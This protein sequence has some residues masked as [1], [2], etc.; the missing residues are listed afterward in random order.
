MALLKLNKGRRAFFNRAPARSLT[1]ALNLMRKKKWVKT[2]KVPCAVCLKPVEEYLNFG[3]SRTL[4]GW[5]YVCNKC[6]REIE[7]KIV[8]AD[9]RITRLEKI[10]SMTK[11]EKAVIVFLILS[12]GWILG[13]FTEAIAVGNLKF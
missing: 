1:G 9:K 3:E 13:R 10:K 8:N 2:K 6:W 7:K 12:F 5:M 4:R 11:I